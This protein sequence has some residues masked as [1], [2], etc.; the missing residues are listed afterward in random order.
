MI[1]IDVKDSEPIDKA[2]RRYKRKSQQIG[3]IKELRNRKHFVK[4]SVE[5]RTEK[6][7]AAYRQ[8]K[9]GVAEQVNTQGVDEKMK[10]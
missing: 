7:K 10:K 4:P 2:L 3:V 6:L 8:S 5:R 1:I 9:F